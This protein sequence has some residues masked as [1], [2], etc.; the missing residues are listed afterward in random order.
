[1]AQV[2]LKKGLVYVGSA[3]SRILARLSHTHNGHPRS[4]LGFF[5]IFFCP[6]MALAVMPSPTA[7]GLTHCPPYTLYPV[8]QAT[9]PELRSFRG[10]EPADPAILPVSGPCF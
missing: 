10:C 6:G 9:G 2:T 4:F 3:K 1:M 7:L 8:A 5:E